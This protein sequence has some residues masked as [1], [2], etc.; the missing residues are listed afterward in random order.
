M[1][2]IFESPEYMTITQVEKKFSPNSVVMV[3][4][5]VNNFA[6]IA[7]YVAAAETLGSEDFEELSIYEKR[8]KNNA[9]NGK[10]FFIMT[11]DPYAGQGLYISQ[12]F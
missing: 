9:D 7:G 5:I 3:K 6:P 1:I 8:L 2:K 10:V 4:C 12:N 11:D